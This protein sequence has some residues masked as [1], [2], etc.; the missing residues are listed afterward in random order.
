MNTSF[1]NEIE[2]LFPSLKKEGYSITSP[3][4]TFYNCIAWAIEDDTKRWDPTPFSGYYWP[5]NVPTLVS[6][7]TYMHLFSKYGYAKC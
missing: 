1:D 7:G 6:V 5:E 4:T 3:E 2:K